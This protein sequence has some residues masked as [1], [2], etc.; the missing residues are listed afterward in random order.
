MARISQAPAERPPDETRSAGH[1]NA[2]GE[3][4]SYQ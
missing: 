4:K 3:Q 2:H 1:D